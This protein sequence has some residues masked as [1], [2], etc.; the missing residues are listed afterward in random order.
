[1]V[2]EGRFRSDLYFRLRVVTL[3]MPPLRSTGGDILRIAEFYLKSHAK[4][5]GKQGLRFSAEAEELLLR[6]SWPG[7]V[8]EMR[9]MLEQTA[10]LATDELITPDQL[11]ITQA[12]P[13]ESPAAQEQ[14]VAAPPA[15]ARDI[16]K[17]SDVERELVCKTLERT[18]WNI[19]KSAKLLGLSRDMLRYRIE[20]Y[21]FVRP[22]D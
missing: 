14:P 19:S 8:R 21:G 7:N 4:R 9:N 13:H 3:S 12:R 6:H 1:M 10:L 16:A 22:A 20:K 11:A 5:Y 18:D 15:A 2:R 17:I